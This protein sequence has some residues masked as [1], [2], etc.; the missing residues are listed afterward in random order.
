MEENKNTCLQPP[1]WRF[2]VRRTY[3][4]PPQLKCK[5]SARGD[6]ELVWRVKTKDF[7]D[8]LVGVN[9]LFATRLGTVAIMPTKREDNTK[10]PLSF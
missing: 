10:N 6:E 5:L 7:S 2:G 3:S 4:A 1:H 9:Y 8:T